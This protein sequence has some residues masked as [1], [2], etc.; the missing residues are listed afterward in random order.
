MRLD[1]IGLKIR[2]LRKEKNL[3]QKD[4]AN[5]ANISRVT[6][7]KIERGLMGVVSIKT[8]DVILDKLDYEISF[9][10]KDKLSFGLTSLDNILENK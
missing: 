6:L 5:I 4:L 10:Q 9:K 1:E 7:G 8:L 3:T 2:S